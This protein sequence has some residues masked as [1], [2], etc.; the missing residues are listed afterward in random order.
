M[1]KSGFTLIEVLIVALILG[2]L[3]AVGVPSFIGSRQGA[4]QNMRQINVATVNAAKDQWAILN[5][6]AVGS[7]VT[8]EQI[9]PF[10]GNNVT[11]IADLNVGGE[12][13]TLGAIGTSAGYPSCE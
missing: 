1:K 5:N 7:A 2:L 9:A 13:I 4:E 3:A 11:S 8:F 10:I 6:A 12:S